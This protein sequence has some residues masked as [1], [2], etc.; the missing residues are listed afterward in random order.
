MHQTHRKYNT[1]CNMKNLFC[2][3]KKHYL[4][5]LSVYLDNIQFFK[6]GEQHR[7][8]IQYDYQLV[9]MELNIHPS[10]TSNLKVWINNR[11]IHSNFNPQKLLQLI[12]N[13]SYEKY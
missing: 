13:Q 8:I 4:F 5:F 9:K 3:K 2:L 7:M 1:N 10:L 12:K 6:S 11:R